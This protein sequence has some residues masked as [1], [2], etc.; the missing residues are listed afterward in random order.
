M[1]EE[2]ADNGPFQGDFLGGMYNE[3]CFRIFYSGAGST[4]FCALKMG[5]CFFHFGT[6]LNFDAPQT[7]LKYLHSPLLR[8]EMPL[9]T[10]P[11]RVTMSLGSPEVNALMSKMVLMLNL[12]NVQNCENTLV[13]VF[14][15]LY[16]CLS[17]GLLHTTS[18][19]CGNW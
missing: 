14:R 1:D 19:C 7:S 16:V 11:S 10:A 5:C 2:S 9:T 12:C 6:L 3:K 17:T 8:G 15:V 4:I 13:R 18:T